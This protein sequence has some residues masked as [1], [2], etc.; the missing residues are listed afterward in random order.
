MRIQSVNVINKNC[1]FR[2]FG[3]VSYTQ[4]STSFYGWWTKDE[5][6]D[7]VE[8]SS[9]SQKPS[10]DVVLTDEEE[11]LSNRVSNLLN[12]LDDKSLIYVVNPDCA[13]KAHLRKQLLGE[14]SFLDS[15]ESIE[16]VYII[17][18]GFKEDLDH[19]IIAKDGKDFYLHGAIRNLT[20][21][22]KILPNVYTYNNCAKFGDV[23][24]MRGGL[25]LKF[26]KD[27]KDNTICSY[28]ALYPRE[29]FLEGDK[30]DELNGGEVINP[31]ALISPR[32]KQMKQVGEALGAM[33]MERQAETGSE[34]A[35]KDIT[36]KTLPHRTFADIAGLDDTIK[37]VK[38]QILYPMIYP[39]AF[40][41]VTN[42]GT[43]FYG[44]PG[45]G[46]TLLA[47]AIIGEAKER[48]DKDIKFICVDGQSFEHKHVGVTEERWRNVFAEAVKNQ[49]CILFIDEIDGVLSERGD[50]DHRNGVVAQLLTL[51]NDIEK[52][53]HKVWV[54]GATNRLDKID[55]AIKRKGRL[56]KFI[57]FKVPDEKE[58]FQILNH[59]LKGK[60]VSD[61]FNRN[62]FAFEIYKKGYTGADIADLVNEAKDNMYER[63]G[64]YEQMDNGTFVD[65]PLDNLELISDDFE[66][67]I[68]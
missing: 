21:P 15:P 38:K 18:A 41:N 39:K 64:I 28:D 45:T 7:T 59:Y 62:S 56:G 25:K 31:E 20:T 50:F 4:N 55:S 22:D 35:N 24:E 9:T 58:C 17:G 34:V 49:P 19:L 67:V 23:I 12:N 16:S 10:F 36:N 66:K 60:N 42:C 48:K 1:L 33:L 52:N 65:K 3:N 40:P 11:E 46:K 53:N 30:Y 6:K 61:E 5:K 27:F 51:I 2:S 43:I 26:K 32:R 63:L 68:K 57:E 13:V 37:L 29:A 14:H 47:E 8:L 44:P 54:I